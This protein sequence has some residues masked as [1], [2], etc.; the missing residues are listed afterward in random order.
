MSVDFVKFAYALGYKVAQSSGPLFDKKTGKI[1]ARHEEDLYG[2]LMARR[3]EVGQVGSQ[4]LRGAMKSTIQ[5]YLNKVPAHKYKES[6]IPEV[7]RTGWKKFVPR[8][9]SI[10]KWLPVRDRYEAGRM[11]LHILAKYL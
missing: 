11:G 5:T 6:H 2:N 8:W 3:V 7:A 9:S 4:A 10:R 1:K